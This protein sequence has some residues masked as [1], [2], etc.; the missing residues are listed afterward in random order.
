MTSR[1]VLCDKIHS[2][3]TPYSERATCG[4]EMDDHCKEG[5]EIGSEHGRPLSEKEI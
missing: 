5:N 1:V 2:H 3:P 4:S